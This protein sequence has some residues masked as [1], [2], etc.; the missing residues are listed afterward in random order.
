MSQ[1]MKDIVVSMVTD[2]DPLNP[3]QR[4]LEAVYLIVT[5]PEF[6]VQK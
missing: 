2:T 3:R 6:S 1:E 4:V 5:S